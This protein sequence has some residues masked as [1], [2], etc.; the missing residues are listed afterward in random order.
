[1]VATAVADED[2]SPLLFY[3]SRLAAPDPL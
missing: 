3:R 2:R 1:V